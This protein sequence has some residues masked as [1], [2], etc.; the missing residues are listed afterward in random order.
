MPKVLELTRIHSRDARERI[1][2]NPL[3]ITYFEPFR[4]GGSNVY[5][6]GRAD[7]ITVHQDVNAVR[8]MLN[9]D[10]G[11]DNHDDGDYVSKL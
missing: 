1:L 10:D 5:V 3:N 6:V 9:D 4:D 2:I 8:V 11:D 7:P